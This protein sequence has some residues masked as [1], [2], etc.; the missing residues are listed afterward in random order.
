MRERNK[1]SAFLH[2]IAQIL[3][4]LIRLEDHIHLYISC[5]TCMMHDEL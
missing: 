2:Q 5:I 1:R 3:E 4:K